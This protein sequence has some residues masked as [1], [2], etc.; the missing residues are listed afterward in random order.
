[1]YKSQYNDW[2]HNVLIKKI[3]EE[4]KMEGNKQK[5]KQMAKEAKEKYVEKKDFVK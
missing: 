1:M 2:G 5:Y 3:A 4:W